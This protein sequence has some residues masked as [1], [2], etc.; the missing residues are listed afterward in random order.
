ME[1]K[2]YQISISELIKMIESDSIELHPSYQRNYIWTIP[3]QKFL[4]D[5]IHK[6]Y[7]LPNFFVYRRNPKLLEMVDGQQRAVT[8]FR[9]FKGEFKDNQRNLYSSTDTEQF[10]NYKLNIIEITK[11]FKES[12][13]LPHLDCTYLECVFVNGKLSI[14]MTLYSKP[15]GSTVPEITK[16]FDACKMI[17]DLFPVEKKVFNQ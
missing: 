14:S 12:D 17:Y 16:L 15:Q 11:I 3:D 8:I 9:Y 5:S 4:I 10:L 1:Y 2:S 6:E 7:P 13:N